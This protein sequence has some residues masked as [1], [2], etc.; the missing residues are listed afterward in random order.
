[1]DVLLSIKPEFVD[2]I[3]LGEKSYEYR[4][5][6]FRRKVKRI[7]IY[8]T[9]PVGLIVGEFEIQAIIEGTPCEIWEQTQKSSGVQKFFFDKYFTG[10]TKAYAIKIG[11]IVRYEIPINP[12]DTLKPFTAPQSFSYIK[13]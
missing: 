1:M 13:I 2:K 12:Y 9:K 3:F 10:R 7:L 8:A 6:I 4:K 5:S 11:S